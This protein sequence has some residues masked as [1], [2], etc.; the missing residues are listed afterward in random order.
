MI[1]QARQP[2]HKPELNLSTAA[3]KSR[4]RFLRDDGGKMIKEGTLMHAADRIRAPNEAVPAN[5]K[6]LLLIGCVMHQL[7]APLA[8]PQD[9]RI[10]P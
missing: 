4:K 9:S 8:Q 7:S 2:G 3:K 5:N 1:G 6:A 10:P